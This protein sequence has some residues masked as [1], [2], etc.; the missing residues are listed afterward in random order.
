MGRNCGRSIRVAFA[1]EKKKRLQNKR[2]LENA[3]R[4][5]AARGWMHP[6][7]PSLEYLRYVLV[8]GFENV[9]FRRLLKGR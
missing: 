7:F 4:T 9:L 3:R 6:C 1:I 2:F 5:G 8:D